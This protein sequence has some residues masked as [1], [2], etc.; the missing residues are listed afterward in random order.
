MA[1]RGKNRPLYIVPN[2]GGSGIGRFLLDPETLRSLV[3]HVE[4]IR[5]ELTRGSAWVD[6]WDNL[7]EGRIAPSDFFDLAVRALPKE[8]NE[9]NTQLVL[10]YLSHAF[11]LFLP[12][13]ERVARAPA[14]ETLLREGISRART[15][16]QKSAWFGAFRD[17]V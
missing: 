5:D 6:L 3:A 1:A 11:W 12:Q 15:T 14:T 9:Q 2:G 17:V 13:S 4:D 16:S 8:D 10:G 7:L